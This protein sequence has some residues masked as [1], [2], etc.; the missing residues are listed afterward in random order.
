MGRPRLPDFHS[1]LKAMVEN[2]YF[3]PPN[4][5]KMEY[6]CI[7][8]ERDDE[9]TQYADNSPYQRTTR[10]SVTV[11]DRDPDGELREMVASLPYSSFER[12]FQAEDL[13][14]DVYNVFF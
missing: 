4:G 3:Q 8:Y 6:P 5:T 10:Y 14:H 12:S 2:V 7:V 1:L 11:I 13:N 9:D